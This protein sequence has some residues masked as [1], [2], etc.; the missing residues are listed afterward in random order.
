[1]KASG[2]SSGGGRRGK[3]KE[4]LDEDSKAGLRRVQANDREIDQGINS[5]SNTLDNLTGI[6]GQMKE[7]VRFYFATNLFYHFFFILI[8]FLFVKCIRLKARIRS[9]NKLK[10]ISKKLRKSKLWSTSDRNVTSI[11][12]T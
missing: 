7:E 4:E 3:E 8:L 6:A 5:I 1:M 12:T 11:K 9:L 2:L 10:I